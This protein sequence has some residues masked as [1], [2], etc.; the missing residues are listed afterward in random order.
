MSDPIRHRHSPI[1]KWIITTLSV[2]IAAHIVPGIHY[3]G[4][5]ALLV[6]SLI[7]GL[8]NIFLKPFL[9]LL[10]LPLLLFSLGFFLLIVNAF[11][12]S[13]AGTLVNGFHV[14]G[15]LPAVL[16]ALVISF[17]SMAANLF[18]GEKKITVGL[19]PANRSRQRSAQEKTRLPNDDGGPVI[20]V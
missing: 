17:S 7:L 4:L 6:A 20:D 12:L 1:Q 19:G 2:L 18:L 13:L 10:S 5:P 14:N 8:L 9:L 3:D 11:L 16:G 15:F